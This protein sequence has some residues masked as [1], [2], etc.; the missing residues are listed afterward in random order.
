MTYAY[1]VTFILNARRVTDWDGYVRAVIL[2]LMIGLC[3]SFFK[4]RNY[5]FHKHTQTITAFC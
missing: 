5:F 4:R 2:P 1:Y 3:A